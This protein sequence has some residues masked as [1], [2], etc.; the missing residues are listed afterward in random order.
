MSLSAWLMNGDSATGPRQLHWWVACVP[1]K[2]SECMYCGLTKKHA[3]VISMMDLCSTQ[4]VKHTRTYH[5]SRCSE[6]IGTPI[7]RQLAI[8]SI[9][10]RQNSNRNAK[11]RW[12]WTPLMLLCDTGLHG[13]RAVVTGTKL[14][15]AE[16]QKRLQD[17]SSD[18]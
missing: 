5:S 6:T 16:K 8:I 10:A 14:L 4:Q 7:G 12:G 2:V 3:Q 9:G 17:L 15:V 11:Y 1:R 18:V 13:C